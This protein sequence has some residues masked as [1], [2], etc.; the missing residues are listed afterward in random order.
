MAY[1]MS[2]AGIRLFIG[3]VQDRWGDHVIMYPAL[4]SFALGLFVA[5]RADGQGEIIAAG[6]LV[7]IGFGTAMPSAQAATVRIVGP[8]RTAVGLATFFLFLDIGSGIG[9]LL[10]GVVVDRAGFPRMFLGVAV[11]IAL[12]IGVYYLVHGRYPRTPAAA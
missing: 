7:G 8:T 3:R 1:G 6:V 11:L 2:T 10:L 12:S 5:S 4:V 9:P